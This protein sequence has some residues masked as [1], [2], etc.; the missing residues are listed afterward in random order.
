MKLEGTHIINA[1][2]SRVYAALS[3]PTI[4]AQCISTIKSIETESESIFKVVLDIS[5]GVIKGTLHG[6]V[7]I[8][9]PQLNQSMTIKIE[10][11]TPVGRLSGTGDLVFQDLSNQQITQVKWLS[12]SPLGVIVAIL[13]RQTVIQVAQSQAELFFSKLETEL[14]KNQTP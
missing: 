8:L 4:L 10:M 7:K 6:K 2:C 1:S 12:K 5:V 9:N 11:Q 14:Q 3:N 13:G